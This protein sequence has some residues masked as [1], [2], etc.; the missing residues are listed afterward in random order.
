[1][2]VKKYDPTKEKALLK[3]CFKKEMDYFCNTHL[4]IE[5]Y[6]QKTDLP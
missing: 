6:D 3:I 1:M 2:A 5:V 4:H